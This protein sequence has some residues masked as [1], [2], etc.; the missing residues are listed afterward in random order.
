MLQLNNPDP[1]NG[2]EVDFDITPEVGYLSTGS[3]P[4]T[5]SFINTTTGGTNC[6]WHWFFDADIV[7][8]YEPVGGI[9]VDVFHESNNHS[10]NTS[11]KYE[12]PG[13]YPVTFTVFDENGCSGNL[14][15]NVTIA[16][17]LECVSN[18]KIR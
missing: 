2:F 5:M 13:I 8:G 12:Y 3:S 14:T 10:G 6:T 1:C 15:K 18:L 16:N 9:D 11:K 7:N 17:P 4:R